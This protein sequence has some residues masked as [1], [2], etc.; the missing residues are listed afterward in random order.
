M[1]VRSDACRQHQD[2]DRRVGAVA[3]LMA[4]RPC[5]ARSRRRHLPS[6]PGPPSGER[7]RRHPRGGPRSHS[8]FRVMRVVR[9]QADRRARSSYMLPH[10]E[11]GA[12]VRADPRGPSSASRRAPSTRSHSSPF[13]IEDLHRHEPRAVETRAG[14]CGELEGTTLS[15]A[16]RVGRRPPGAQRPLPVVPS[17]APSPST[18]AP[19]G[20]EGSTASPMPIGPSP[21]HVPVLLNS[22]V[23]R[24]ENH[25]AGGPCRD[26]KRLARDKPQNHGCR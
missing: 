16:G 3:D 11:L 23:P 2:T 6:A 19:R 17:E 12:D 4:R 21:R 18:S 9:P 24:D 1:T 20:A 14:Y 25:P 10:D 13:E 22:A 8:S 7:K 15:D 5:R 26:R